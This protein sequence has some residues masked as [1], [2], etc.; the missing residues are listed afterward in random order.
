MTEAS[1]RG[2]GADDVRFLVEKKLAPLGLFAGANGAVAETP[3]LD[4]MLL[5]RQFGSSVSAPSS[6]D[7]AQLQRALRSGSVEI[8]AGRSD[9]LLHDLVVHADLGVDVPRSLQHALG[10]SVGA[11]VRFELGI[12]HPSEH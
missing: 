6:A 4:P 12:A 5:L 10:T 11:D 3:K 8:V 9:H 2:V 7:R 1:G